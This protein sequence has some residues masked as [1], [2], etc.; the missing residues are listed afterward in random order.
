MFCSFQSRFGQIPVRNNPPDV[1]SPERVGQRIPSSGAGW[2]LRRKLH[3]QH[4]GEG[5]GNRTRAIRRAYEA[6]THL[7]CLAAPLRASDS[8]DRRRQEGCQ[9]EV[10]RRRARRTSVSPFTPLLETSAVHAEAALVLGSH[11]RSSLFRRAREQ[12]LSSAA[13]SSSHR[14]PQADARHRKQRQLPQV[15][16][17]SSPS[18]RRGLPTGSRLLPSQRRRQLEAQVGGHGG[19]RGH[20][21][22]ALYDGAT[23][24]WLS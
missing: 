6:S 19:Q 8:P 10:G 3:D 21:S 15:G 1:R 5:R 20:S 11:S 17:D 9:E 22:C 14:R 12:P 23:C 7:T 13:G 4:S 24:A 2:A 16:H 18:S